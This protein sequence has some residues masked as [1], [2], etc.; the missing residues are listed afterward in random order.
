MLCTPE[1]WCNCLSYKPCI[2]FSIATFNSGRKGRERR[3]TKGCPLKTRSISWLLPQYRK[4]L[5]YIHMFVFPFRIKILSF[6]FFWEKY[7]EESFNL[8]FLRTQSRRDKLRIQFFCNAGFYI[9]RQRN[10]KHKD[11]TKIR[12]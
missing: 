9:I 10:I 11:Q 7:I 5:E 8:C 12:T 1:S 3:K 4:T 6:F 2:Y